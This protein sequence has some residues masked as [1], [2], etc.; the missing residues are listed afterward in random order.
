MHAPLFVT[1]D[2]PRRNCADVRAGANKKEY[3]KEE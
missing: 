1:I 3:D 2:Q